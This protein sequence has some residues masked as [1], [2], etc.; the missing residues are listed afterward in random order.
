[1][2]GKTPWTEMVLYYLL[3]AISTFFV[4]VDIWAARLGVLSISMMLTR[5]FPP[6]N[7][8]DNPAWTVGAIDMFTWLILVAVGL[9][10][11]ILIEYRLRRASDTVSATSGAAQDGGPRRMLRVA[12]ITWAWQAGVIIVSLLIRLLAR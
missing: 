2:E 5:A 12:M 3:W 10:F 6:R 9:G 1:M 11:T 4:L 7:S 8:A